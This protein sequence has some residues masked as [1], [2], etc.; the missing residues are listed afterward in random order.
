MLPKGASYIQLVAAPDGSRMLYQQQRVVGQGGFQLF[1]IN[2]RNGE[3]TLLLETTNGAIAPLFAPDGQTI[4]FTTIDQ[5]TWQF[6]TLNL[7]TKATRVL[8]SGRLSD[9]VLWPVGWT[10][11][12]ML[13]G[14]A[15]W[16]SDAPLRRLSLLNPA[17]SAIQ[18][19]YADDFWS[20]TPSDGGRFV[21][22]LGGLQAMG[23]TPDLT[24]T[25]VEVATGR[26]ATIARNIRASVSRMAW[27][28]DMTQL[29][30]TTADFETGRTALNVVDAEG[31]N[32]RVL[33]FPSTDRMREL[34]DAA[35]RSNATIVVVQSNARYI[36]IYDLP[37]DDVRA[38]A[39]VSRA[40]LPEKKTP[41]QNVR[42]LYMGGA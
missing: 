11:R 34:Q 5:E 33:T 27:S 42:L 36:N 39:L 3:Q 6:Q 8:K 15:L 41:S 23:G 13:V 1:S 20:A 31:R 40:S 37:A 10:A 38:G 9:R 35:W 21:A 18:V 22:V 25:A 17:T 32:A 4:A 30:Y 28:P 14:E 2:A 19:L 29:L 7:Q 16:A 12:G 24:I 26:T